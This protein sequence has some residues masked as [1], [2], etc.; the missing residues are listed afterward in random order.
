MVCLRVFFQRLLENKLL[1]R[2]HCVHQG[3]LHLAP[4]TPVSAQGL[5]VLHNA[6]TN[7]GFMIA[8][9]SMCLPL[10]SELKTVFKLHWPKLAGGVKPA[11]EV[12]RFC[13]PCPATAKLLGKYHLTA[14]MPAPAVSMTPS[15]HPEGKE[16][17]RGWKLP[18]SQ[19]GTQGKSLR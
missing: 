4:C 13:R 8:A 14:L 3:W 9:M 11:H 17:N 12:K 6:N 5:S 19:I 10:I 18:L 16:E 15:W 1:Y 2:L 7:A